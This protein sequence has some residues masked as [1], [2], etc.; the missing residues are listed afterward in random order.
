MPVAKGDSRGIFGQAAGKGASPNFFIIR[1]GR[2]TSGNSPA[3]PHAPASMSIRIP[4]VRTIND[5]HV[6]ER[7]FPDLQENHLSLIFLALATVFSH[8]LFLGGFSIALRRF[9]ASSS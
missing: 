5:G 6:V 7:A 9:S 3:R 8:A 2:R 1:T 4:G